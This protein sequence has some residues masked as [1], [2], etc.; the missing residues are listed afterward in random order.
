MFVGMS[1]TGEGRIFFWRWAN[2]SRLRFNR[3][4][5]ECDR[6]QARGWTYDILSGTW[7]WMKPLNIMSPR[8]IEWKCRVKLAG[9][10]FEQ[11][12]SV[13]NRCLSS[14]RDINSSGLA[15]PSIAKM[16]SLVTEST[17][18]YLV[19][20]IYIAKEGK[21]HREGSGIRKGQSVHCTI[22]LSK[23]IDRR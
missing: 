23:W 4:I 14:N 15:V 12:T 7:M 18:K 9:S 2:F 11:P 3:Q 8:R 19:W 10:L 6:L 1:F 5:L 20:N 16:N 13:P 21:F 17:T 22:N